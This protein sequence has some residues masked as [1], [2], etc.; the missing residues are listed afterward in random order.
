MTPAARRTQAIRFDD[1]GKVDDVAI[2]SDLF[3][4][5]RMSATCFW[6]CAYRG[7]KRIAFWLNSKATI[8]VTIADDSIGFEDDT[9]KRVR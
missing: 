8:N 7:K 2:S 1:D 5:E 4:I 9:A 6:A 3:R